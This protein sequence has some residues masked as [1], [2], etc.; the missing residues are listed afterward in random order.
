[1]SHINDRENEPINNF[2]KG[3]RFE[4]NI[5]F[6][7]FNL[8][9]DLVNQYCFKIWG[10][11]L[12]WR[13][14]P[15]D[16]LS[17]F[18][19]IFLENMDLSMSSDKIIMWYGYGSYYSEERLYLLFFYHLFVQRIF[20]KTIEKSFEQA[21][22]DWKK[23]FETNKMPITIYL[24]LPITNFEGAIKSF[25]ISDN[26]DLIKPFT[27]NYLIGS[28]RS[29]ARQ[30]SEIFCSILLRLTTFQSFDQN[31]NRDFDKGPHSLSDN[32]EAYKDIFIKIRKFMLSFY[33]NG[34]P[35]IKEDFEIFYPWWI[36]EDLKKF[37]T[38]KSLTA[39]KYKVLK[40]DDLK[41]LT[42]LFEQIK[43]FN[44]LKDTDLELVLFNYNELHKKNLPSE[45]ILYDFIILENLFTRKAKME[46]SFRLSLNLTL[47][48]SEPKDKFEEKFLLYEELYVLRSSIIHGNDWPTKKQKKEKFLKQLGLDNF[49]G[50]DEFALA[51][52]DYI[53][54][55]INKA[56]IKI[57]QL[58][59]ESPA[60]MKEFKKV[61]FLLNSEVFKKKK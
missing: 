40:L 38:S 28:S 12:K 37:I 47:F 7:E 27:Y 56:I 15:N 42:N 35:M 11:N 26:L 41:Q 1:M 58:K 2:I 51:A 14:I 25:R 45:L 34:Y 10:S 44:L 17:L 46:L 36:Q 53:I 31:F 52:H 24:V 57:I 13:V 19:K 54:K 32:E 49:E 30:N 61:Y 48:L 20:N 43:E 60:I 9:E 50:K 6:I 16:R 55:D 5:Y 21:L 29:Q 23:A 3:V 33:L 8:F 39:P 59:K 22:F 18:R 4:E